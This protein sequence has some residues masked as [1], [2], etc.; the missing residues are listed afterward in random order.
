VHIDATKRKA[1][2]L[3]VVFF[4][5][6]LLDQLFAEQKLAKW[7]QSCNMPLSRLNV[8]DS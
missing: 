4:V 1:Q 8:D 3:H 5:V 6:C 7:V 2:Q